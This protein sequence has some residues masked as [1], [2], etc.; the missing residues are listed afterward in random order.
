[1]DRRGAALHTRVACNRAAGNEEAQ[2]H[3]PGYQAIEYPLQ[4][5]RKEL[6][7][8]RSG[9]REVSQTLEGPKIAKEIWNEE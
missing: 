9:R 3:S 2:H 6:Q 1:M 7:D 8:R 4:Q 5:Q